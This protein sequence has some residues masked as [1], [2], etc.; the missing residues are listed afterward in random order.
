MTELNGKLLNGKTITAAGGIV[1]AIVLI[2]LVFS[3]L[4]DIV[5][6][7]IDAHDINTIN[8]QKEIQDDWKKVLDN[9]SAVIKE[10]TKAIIQNASI[11]ESFQK[12]LL[13]SKL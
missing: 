5:I 11:I 12:A 6:N 13:R 4:D 9:N 2:V 3:F 8:V 7:K 1:I 10:N